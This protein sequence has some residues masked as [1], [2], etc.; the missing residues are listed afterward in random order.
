MEETLGC[1]R[2]GSITLMFITFSGCF[3]SFWFSFISEIKKKKK[4][5]E[6]ESKWKWRPIEP[7]RKPTTYIHIHKKRYDGR[8][9]TQSDSWGLRCGGGGYIIDLSIG[10]ARR[11]VLPIEPWLTWRIGLNLH[12]ERPRWW[13]SFNAKYILGAIERD[14]RRPGPPA[15]ERWSGVLCVPCCVQSWC[16]TARL[17]FCLRMLP[18]GA[19]RLYSLYPSEP[20]PPLALSSLSPSPHPSFVSCGLIDMTDAA[21]DFTPGLNNIHNTFGTAATA[22]IGESRVMLL[23]DCNNIILLTSGTANAIALYMCV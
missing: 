9:R 8:E 17:L 7:T 14:E 3:S 12:A 21:N 1:H 20:P 23:C 16:S 6:W 13:M 2:N 4:K 10:W 5:S 18:R 22:H 19:A 15:G 11:R